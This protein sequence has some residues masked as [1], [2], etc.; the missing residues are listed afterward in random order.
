MDANSDV[1]VGGFCR[2]HA[3]SAN[4][5]GVRTICI[6]GDIRTPDSCSFPRGL[7][8]GVTPVPFALTEAARR[9]S[10]PRRPAPEVG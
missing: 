4:R 1:E 2:V 10:L 8:A 9:P 3:S 7:P 6:A 5:R